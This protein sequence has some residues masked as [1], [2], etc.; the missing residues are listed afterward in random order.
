MLA[1]SLK[2]HTST[3]AQ[4]MPRLRKMTRFKR[5]HSRKGLEALVG[6]PFRIKQI[7]DGKEGLKCP[8]C[9]TTASPI[10]STNGN[11]HCEGCESLLYDGPNDTLRT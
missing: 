3:K 4:A 8:F 2:L 11:I 6:S 7:Q 9:K 1:C 5:G 10:V